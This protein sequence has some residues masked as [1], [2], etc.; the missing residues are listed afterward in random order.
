MM[1][2]WA[3]VKVDNPAGPVYSGV[4]VSEPWEATDNT[5]VFSEVSYLESCSFTVVWSLKKNVD[6]KFNDTIPVFGA[7][8]IP[9]GDWGLQSVKFSLHPHCICAINEQTCGSGVDKGSASKT[10][11][12]IRWFNDQIEHDR[13]LT[14]FKSADDPNAEAWEIVHFGDLGATSGSQAVL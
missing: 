7:V 8:D 2:G 5:L 14:L 4:V 6:V 10:P 1:I 11:A 3:L 13:L 9:Y 12:V